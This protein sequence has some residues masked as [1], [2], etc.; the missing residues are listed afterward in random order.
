MLKRKASDAN[1]LF[2]KVC[3]HILEYNNRNPFINLTPIF[4]WIKHFKL[5]TWQN[6]RE[7]LLPQ[8]SPAASQAP[9]EIRNLKSSATSV[10]YLDA[11]HMFFLQQL[12]EKGLYIYVFLNWCLSTS[13]W[14]CVK[15]IL[16]E[17][18]ICKSSKT[19]Q[20]AWNC[21]KLSRF[22]WASPFSLEFWTIH[23]KPRHPNKTKSMKT[24]YCEMPSE[25]FS[26]VA[27]LQQKGEGNPKW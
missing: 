17:F 25:S 3:G 12:L 20:C 22:G 11:A 18:D 24:K 5:A 8:A 26:E 27:L 23:V 13:F 15:N 14:H 21:C 1:I 9:K 7:M 10:V 16:G 6:T 2:Q 19:W 4:L